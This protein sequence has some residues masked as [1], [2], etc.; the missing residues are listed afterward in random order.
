MQEDA[1][2]MDL[3]QLASLCQR[4]SGWLREFV[5]ASGG[6]DNDPLNDL[7]PLVACHGLTALDIRNCN[8][9]NIQNLVPLSALIG[10]KELHLPVTPMLHGDAQRLQALFG[11]L[12]GLRSITLQSTLEAVEALFNEDGT[13]ACGPLLQDL[14][15]QVS[16]DVSC[17]ARARAWLGEVPRGGREQQACML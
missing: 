9:I 4:T 15:L 8:Q 6:D 10:L 14:V 5:L 1:G 2:R 11:G 3:A 16:F 17:S 12:V 7:T 13:H